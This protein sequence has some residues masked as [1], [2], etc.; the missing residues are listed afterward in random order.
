MEGESQIPHPLIQ[1]RASDV[2]PPPVT[3][4]AHNDPIGAFAHRLIEQF[5]DGLRRISRIHLF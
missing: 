3:F 5:V 2:I 1:L 4:V